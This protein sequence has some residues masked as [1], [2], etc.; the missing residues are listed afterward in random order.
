[1]KLKL[2]PMLLCAALLLSVPVSAD[3]LGEPVDAWCITL[4]DG[5]TLTE[6]GFWTGADLRTEHYLSLSPEAAAVPVV[7]SSDTLWNKSGVEEAAALLRADGREVLGGSNGG[8]YTVA[9]GEPVG[10][11]V[12]GGVLRADDGWLE[13]VGFCADG[14]AVFGKPE[15][16]LTLRAGETEL[17]VAALNR[18]AGDGL[19]IWTDDCTGTIRPAGENWCLLCDAEGSIPLSGSVAL[20]VKE[21][22]KTADALSVPE[23]MLLMLLPAGTEEEPQ[24]LPEYL[25]EGE[26]LTL[27]CSCAPGWEDVD[28]AVGILYPLIEDGKILSGLGNDAA[29]RTAIGMKADG[30]VILYTVDG[31][32]S[33]YSVGTGLAGTAKR[34]AELGC[35]R[36]GALDGGGSTQLSAVMPGDTGLSVVNRPSD[37]SVR[38][39]VNYI[40]LTAPKTPVGRAARLTAY[41]LSIHA[42]AG[43][44]IPL[45][46][47]VTDRNGHPVS[48]VPALRYTVSSGLGTVRGGVYRAE[49][50]GCGTI[51]V[52]AYGLADAVIPIYV[53]ESPAELALYGEVYGK[54]TEALT[55]EPGQEVDLTVRAKDG[56]VALLS[57][58]ECFTWELEPKAGTVDETGHL[59]PRDVSGTGL[60][61]VSAGES[62]VEIPITVWTGIPFNDVAKSDAYFDAV[63]YVYD[64]QIFNGTGAESFEPLTVMNRAMLVTVLWR[65]C[66]SP[67]AEQSAGFADVA[68]DSW[69]GPAVAWAAESGLVNG[70]SETQFAPLDNLTKEQILTILHRWAGT[71]EPAGEQEYDL[72]DTQEYAMNAVT[73]ALENALVSGDAPEGLQPRSPM[74]RAAVA[75]VLMR[76]DMLSR[77][78][79]K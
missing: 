59:V 22:Q 19:R 79:E 25:F 31:R 17:P 23:G 26:E 37:G 65:M 51:T 38:K 2:I 33:G 14:S 5:V 6:T 8:F 13:A 7:V 32:Q 4:A 27:E 67:A 18:A 34:L 36:A 10:L 72:A 78:A 64:H 16:R 15:T 57:S 9:T 48:S 29:P 54:K 70:Y 62:F 42:V 75:E 47:K 35:V 3:V 73:W 69:F 11:V 66:G 45:E 50:T 55:L 76:W 60:L 58:D 61:R 68:A 56:H 74:H 39:V 1:M 46:V 43:A 41:P 20:T 28:S 52:S 71:P 30:S 24:P 49:G 40:L 53:T 63:K 12:S 21:V 44:E 77:T